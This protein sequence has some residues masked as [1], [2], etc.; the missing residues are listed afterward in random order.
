MLNLEKAVANS[1]YL[2]LASA[3]SFKR[4]FGLWPK[5]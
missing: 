1:V 3:L 4:F 5:L 2:M